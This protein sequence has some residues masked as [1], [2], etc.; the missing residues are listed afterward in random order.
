M[1]KS[2]LAI[3][4][5]ILI[6]FPLFAQP[7]YVL[8]RKCAVAMAAA[9]VAA[10]AFTVLA[11]P[12][13]LAF[14]GFVPAGIAGGSLAAAW[15]ATMGGVVAGGGLFA[16]LQSISVAGLSWSG[17]TIVSGT[18]AAAV[19]AFCEMLPQASKL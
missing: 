3:S 7:K 4:V 16:L 15:Q 13:A 11:L 17:T 10:G 18:S 2:I 6:S 19:A 12:H 1:K 5:A 14:V 8:T 9:G